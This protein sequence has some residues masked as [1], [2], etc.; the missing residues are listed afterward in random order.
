MITKQILDLSLGETISVRCAII[1]YY[2]N[3]GMSKERDTILKKLGLPIFK[4][5]GSK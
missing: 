5:K 3:A 4:R 1:N 2:D